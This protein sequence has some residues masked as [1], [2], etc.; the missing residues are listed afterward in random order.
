M[1]PYFGFSVDVAGTGEG[2][3]AGVGAGDGAGLGAGVGAGAGAGVGMVVAAGP[4]ETSIRA[5]IISKL[6]II[7]SVLVFMC[8]PLFLFLC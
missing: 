5:A 7:Q 2:V 6:V 1:P 3:G 8:L 4:Q